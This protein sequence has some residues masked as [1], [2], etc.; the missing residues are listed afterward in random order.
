MKWA[1]KWPVLACVALLL[2]AAAGG[3]PYGFYVLVR[4]VV[5]VSCAYLAV[6]AHKAKREPW[7]WVM[8]ALAL[9]FNP[10]LLV[11]MPR[12]DWVFFDLLGAGLLAAPLLASLRSQERPSPPDTT[13]IKPLEDRNPHEKDGPVFAWHVHH[14][15]LVE[16]LREPIEKRIA[17]IRKWKPK[18]EIAVRLGLL[19]VVKGP[20]PNGLAEAWAAYEKAERWSVALKIA[21]GKPVLYI[22]ANKVLA[23]ADFLDGSWPRMSIRDYAPPSMAELRAAQT[24][25]HRWEETEV[26]ASRA[27]NAARDALDRAKEAHWGEVLALHARECPNCPWNGTSIF[28]DCERRGSERIVLPGGEGAY[29][30]RLRKQDLMRGRRI[31]RWLAE[32][33]SQVH[34]VRAHILRVGIPAA[35]VLLSL[36][37]GRHWIPLHPILEIIFFSVVMTF[38]FFYPL[39]PGYELA[40]LAL[41]RVWPSR[42]TDDPIRRHER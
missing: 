17:Y 12:S 7:M 31:E 39:R 3:E 40:A 11:R 4:L 38:I 15:E 5:C 10:V 29:A 20:L 1:S 37:W 33:A 27:W 30:R 16:M 28:P 35:V 19:K 9:L 6:A 42:R 34:S 32:P 14:G 36:Y 26:E 2:I 18:E 25:A 23:Y 24:Q 41:L 22:D 13:P 8:G 21:G